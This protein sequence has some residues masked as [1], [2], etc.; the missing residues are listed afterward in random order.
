MRHKLLSTRGQG[1]AAN[2]RAKRGLGWGLA[3]AMRGGLGISEGGDEKELVVQKQRGK[4]SQAA[5]MAL[6]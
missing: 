1:C 2:R 4:S 3:G 6:R 5:G